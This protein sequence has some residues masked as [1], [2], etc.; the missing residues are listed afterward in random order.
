V[1]TFRGE[2]WLA[3]YGEPV[4]RE[5]G[6]PRPALILHGSRFDMDRAGLAIAV[7][8]TSRDRGYPTHVEV[9]PG[10]SG[11]RQT[12]WAMGE[13]LRAISTSRL[14]RRLGEVDAAV[15][16]RMT[17]VLRHLLQML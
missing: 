15:L 8:L 2:V 13:Q 4:G 11:L 5:Q 12:S 6:Y 1:K 10:P 16:D 9:A 7:P 14:Q 17:L 3:D